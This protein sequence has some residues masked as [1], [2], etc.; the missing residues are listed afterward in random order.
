MPSSIC[1]FEVKKNDGYTINNTSTQ[2]SFI[3]KLNLQNPNINITIN[4]KKIQMLKKLN[5]HLR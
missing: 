1:I 5:L 3:R 4:T 2:Y